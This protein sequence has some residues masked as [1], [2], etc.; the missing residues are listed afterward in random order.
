HGGDGTAEARYLETAELLTRQYIRGA[1]WLWRTGNPA[2][3]IHYF[4]L[5]DDV[6]HRMLGWIAQGTPRSDASIAAR[7]QPWRARLWEL[8]DI[9][10]AAVGDLA[11]ASGATLFV[12]G[13]HGMRPTWRVFRPNV[14]LAQAGLLAADTAG[15]IDLA[16]TRAL[17][18]SGYWVS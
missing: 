17:T 1:E 18:A 7:L 14:A 12:S 6:D 15:R 13:D 11:R 16:R 8:V 3:L 5:G 4:P 9:Q 10:F 2:L